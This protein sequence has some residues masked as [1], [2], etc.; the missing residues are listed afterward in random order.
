MSDE[1]G[2]LVPR[3]MQDPSAIASFDDD[4]VAPGRRSVRPFLITGGRT[5][6]AVSLR[7]ES[8]L[9]AVDDPADHAFEHA[10]ILA[11]AL[12]PVAVAEVAAHMKLPFGAV[13]VLASDLIASGAL[14]VRQPSSSSKNPSTI[15][16]LIDAVSSL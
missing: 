5:G 8:L 10:G 6:S 2:R 13:K 12:R 4:I 1:N 3:F 11:C 14:R 15:R 7:L 9:L 16:E